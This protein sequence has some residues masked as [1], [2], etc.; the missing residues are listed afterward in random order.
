MAFPRSTNFIIG[1]F[2]LGLPFLWFQ[3]PLEVLGQVGF[4]GLA[5]AMLIC[6]FAGF[7]FLAIDR[8]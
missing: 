8:K 2:V 6:A 5:G 1:S 3:H 4:Y 7:A